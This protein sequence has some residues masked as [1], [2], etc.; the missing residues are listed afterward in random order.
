M[1]A[2]GRLAAGPCPVP[3][4]T[5]RAS[6]RPC[7]PA[8]LVAPAGPPSHGGRQYPATSPPGPAARAGGPG[9]RGR[10][11]VGR[12]T[13]G[14]RQ[15]ATSTQAR[16]P[17]PEARLPRAVGLVGLAAARRGSG[18]R[19]RPGTGAARCPVPE[20]EASTQ[21]SPVGAPPGPAAYGA[22]AACMAR[23]SASRRLRGGLARLPGRRPRHPRATAT[24]LLR[25]GATASGVAARVA[26]AGR[27]PC[28]PQ[29]ST[30]R[31]YSRLGP[32]PPPTAVLLR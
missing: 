4:G 7:G 26:A 16:P 1:G 30:A 32:R 12:G 13:A 3:A 31:Q 24:P 28:Q 11:P 27:P 22:A 2:R 5:G 23:C 14:S 25:L 21:A 8:R 19:L 20:A 18:Q 9:S 6:A 15:P 29:P 17:G 10:G